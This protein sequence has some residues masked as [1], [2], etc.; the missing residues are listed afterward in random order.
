MLIAL[1]ILAIVGA[2]TFSSLLGLDDEEALN[3]SAVHIKAILNEARSLTTSSK[4]DMQYGVHFDDDAIVRFVGDA[5]SSGDSD[6][7][8]YFLHPKI[9]VLETDFNGGGDDIL[10]Q[11]LTG[12]TDDFGT[13]TIS[14]VSD[15]AQTRVIT[16]SGTGVIE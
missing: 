5:Y 3:T 10:F 15:D 14:L 8:E 9:Q 1:A 13:V 16:I 11:R 2:L 12:D 6:N 4:N 7:V